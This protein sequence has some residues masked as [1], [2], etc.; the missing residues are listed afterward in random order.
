[1]KT[2]I[3]IT[4]LILVGTLLVL[5][6]CYKKNDISDY[7]SDTPTIYTRR[8]DQETVYLKDNA[9]EVVTVRT[10]TEN[11][12]REFSRIDYND[13][14]GFE[15]Y[16][17]CTEKLV[18]EFKEKGEPQRKVNLVKENKL[19]TEVRDVS[20]LSMDFVSDGVCNVEYIVRHLCINAEGDY[21]PLIGTRLQYKSK[22]RL[23]L[24]DDRWKVDYYFQGPTEKTD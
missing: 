12:A 20:I 10:V 21:A 16:E 2:K 3:I 15:G 8:T 5:S 13:V 6:G 14:T 7:I 18:K 23:V 22:I 19:V 17:Y 1:M 11:F 24:E 4:A 9:P